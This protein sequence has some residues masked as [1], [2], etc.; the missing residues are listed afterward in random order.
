M[1][2]CE[3][4]RWRNQEMDPATNS[5][6]D[7]TRQVSIFREKISEQ[8]PLFQPEKNRYHLYISPACPWAHRTLIFHHLKGL[9]NIISVS[10][11][12]DV[13][14]NNGWEF[15]QEIKKNRDPLYNFDYL[16]QIYTLADPQFS[17]RVT[18]PVL[19]DKKQKTIVNNE[20]SDIIRIFNSAFNVITKNDTDF[21]PKKWQK[22]IDNIN[23][24]I[25]D[26]VNNGVYRCGFAKTQEAYDNA[27]KLLFKTL[28]K[29]EK[30]L[31]KNNYLVGDRI[32]EADWRLFTTLIRFD[33]VYHN[34]F[35]CNM[36]KIEEYPGLST[37]IKRLYSIKG[38]ANTVD[39]TSIKN[40]YYQSH[41]TINPLKIVPRGPDIEWLK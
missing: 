7:F 38:I 23:Q 3:K 6:G 19:W 16:H 32:T 36:K 4:G 12:A 18:V 27:Y 9:K 39:I 37:Y 8:H 15:S 40:H 24:L 33:A 35:K 10:T 1:G 28:S 20:S 26:N 11:V 17:G 22:K 13:V 31:S 30:K 5:K 41:P 2:Y 25:Y 14:S 34:H 21:Y 29:L